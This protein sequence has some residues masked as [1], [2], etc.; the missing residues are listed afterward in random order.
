MTEPAPDTAAPAESS[1]GNGAVGRRPAPR[2]A[3]RR[4][5]TTRTRAAAAEPTPS[6]PSVER[7]PRGARG[8]AGERG[9]PGAAGERGTG[10][11][12]AGEPG[13]RAAGESAA[14]PGERGP[15]GEPGPRAS[16]ASRAS[17]AGRGE[18]GPARRARRARPGRAGPSRDRPGAGPAGRAAASRA[19]A[20]SRARGSRRPAR[21]RGPSRRARPRRPARA[22]RRSG[23]PDD[24]L[25]LMAEFACS[26]A[27]RHGDVGQVFSVTRKSIDLFRP[28]PTALTRAQHRGPHRGLPEPAYRAPG[29]ALCRRGSGRLAAQVVL[30]LLHHR[31][32]AVDLAQPLQRVDEVVARRR[33]SSPVR[34]A[35]SRPS[36]SRRP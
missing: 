9:E 29:V 34:R 18:R 23:G 21:A 2:A 17:A 26:R 36:G 31:V 25:D 14:E 1:N 33:S 20:A 15:A 8:P 24:P 4:T 30:Q 27:D 5:G 16:A 12:S 35:P 7:G 6:S 32:R 10:R 3:T 13:R 19:S 28:T 22:G 11:G